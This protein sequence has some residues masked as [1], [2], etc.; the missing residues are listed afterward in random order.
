MAV[1]DRFIKMLS[2][3]SIQVRLN[4]RQ[5]GIA[6]AGKWN[7]AKIVPREFGFC[8]LKPNS[9]FPQDVLIEC[10]SAFEKAGISVKALSGD[11]F[12]VQLDNSTLDQGAEALIEFVRRGVNLED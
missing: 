6:L 7:F 1:F 8:L 9:R 5:D 2:D 4:F 10:R 12:S 3:H 11:R